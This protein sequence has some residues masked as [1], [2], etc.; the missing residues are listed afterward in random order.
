MSR[1]FAADWNTS[2]DDPEQGS[3]PWHERGP[4]PNLPENFTCRSGDDDDNASIQVI[5]PSRPKDTLLAGERLGQVADANFNRPLGP[6]PVQQH[7]RIGSEIKSARNMELYVVHSTEFEL[8]AGDTMVFVDLPSTP[9]DSRKQAD[10]DGIAYKSQRFRVHSEKL[11]A[12]GSSKFSE[13]LRPTYQ[14]RIQRRRKMVN[15]L[16]EGVKYLLDLTPPSEGDELVFQM[17]ELSL[18]PGIMRWWS[19][20]K[21]H[22]VDPSLVAGHDDV[23]TCKRRATITPE[24]NNDEEPS[25]L[26]KDPSKMSAVDE[27]ADNKMLSGSDVGMAKLVPPTPNQLIKMKAD[28]DES[29]YKMPS[30][31][32]IPDYCLVRHRNAII[33][34]LVLIEGRDVLMD[35]A[36][37]VWTLVALAKIFDCPS[38][39][40]DRVVQWLL[41]GTN[42]RFLEVLPEEA[43]RIGFALEISQ[44]TQCAFRILVNEMALSEAA[45]DGARR[46]LSRTSIFGRRLGECGDEL[47]NLIQHAARALLERVTLTRTQLQ[48]PDLFDYWDIQAWSKLRRLELLLTRGE[49]S[50]CRIALNKLRHLMRDLQDKVTSNFNNADRQHIHDAQPMLGSMDQDRATYV[51]P[52][53]FVKL[54]DILCNANLVQKL[55]CPFIYNDLGERCSWAPLYDGIPSGERKPGRPLSYFQLLEEVAQALQHAAFDRPTVMCTEE[56]AEF[57]DPVRNLDGSIKYHHVKVPLVDL[58]QLDMEVKEALRPL[59]RSWIRHDVDPPLNITRHMLLTLTI[60]EMKFLP[61]WAGGFDDGTG[62]VFESFVPP[63]DMGPNGPGPAYHTGRTLPSAPASIS[64]SMIEEMTALR[65]KGSTTAASIDVHD[66][67]STVYQPDRVIADDVSI[68]SDAFT[69]DTAEYQE[70]MFAIPV[71]HQGVGQAVGMVVESDMDLESVTDAEYDDVGRPF[72]DVSDSEDS[73]VVV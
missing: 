37:R 62:G 68:M 44:V 32:Q 31:R 16:P 20:Y 45:T 69:A 11:L 63:T 25:D 33:R 67:I 14:F 10:C 24:L 61:L 15:K 30:F 60:N 53:D 1:Q 7:L 43:L 59:T 13:M 36:S 2:T 4:W 73:V 17:T 39:V 57:L 46:E 48:S 9:K 3:D 64:E 34:L 71:E 42:N 72:S 58:A 56:W 55:L 65:F 22:D 50:V 52:Q 26:Q 21:F 38:V 23:C 6:S 70:A 28:G 54:S 27:L 40:R 19:S 18:T 12:T 8:S 47:N 51:L 66:S 29:I 41:H 5:P 35:S 49:E